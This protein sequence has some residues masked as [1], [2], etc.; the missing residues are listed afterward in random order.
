LGND[1]LDRKLYHIIFNSDGLIMS[2]DAA[3][4]YGIETG[5]AQ[6]FEWDKD[7]KKRLKSAEPQKI[8][9]R[10]LKHFKAAIAITQYFL[11]NG[12]GIKP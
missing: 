12:E 5:A 6:Y 8:H 2:K 7:N 11:N 10:L 4:M 1:L 3:A 9:E